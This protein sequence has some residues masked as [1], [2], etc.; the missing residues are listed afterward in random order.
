MKE[1]SEEEF[2]EEKKR[3]GVLPVFFW[4]FL[5]ATV[6]VLLILTATLLSRNG[7]FDRWKAQ[8]T[9]WKEEK[10][11]IKRAETAGEK[12]VHFFGPSGIAEYESW[13]SG[14]W[15]NAIAEGIV[16]GEAGGIEPEEPDPLR[17]ALTESP[18]NGSESWWGSAKKITSDVTVFAQAE[19][20]LYNAPNQ[21]GTVYGYGKA[22]EA[23]RLMAVFKDGWYVVSDG[24]YYYCSEGNRYT[25][26]DLKSVDFETM[27]KEVEKEKV[28]HDVSLILQEPELPHGCEVTG[29][30]MLLSYYGYAEDKC[31]LA[32]Q[33]LP[34]GAWG[35]TNFRKAFV[36][37][38][39]KKVASAGCYA[40]VIADTANRY[41]EEKIGVK[42]SEEGTQGIFEAEIRENLSV[43]PNMEDT[44]KIP[45][46][47]AKEG[48]SFEELLSMVGKGPVLAWMTMELK[49]PYI[50][51]VWDVDGEELY[52]QNCEH[53][54]VLTGYDLDKGVFYGADPL[55]GNCEYDMK[56]FSIRFQTMYS[57]V[58]V[59]E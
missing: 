56:L 18:V 24:R 6:A 38:P 22:G 3:D 34:K 58:V 10:E 25:L 53:C 5:V 59:M 29:L 14:E 55:Y 8:Y 51:Q 17:E 23:F 19:T 57:Q 31:V 1:F 21:S 42:V 50:A 28:Y 32:D 11:A 41:L 40:T 48:V 26:V 27:F 45:K 35:S 2:S 13:F 43:N 15:K 16:E 37:D 52:W 46:A 39:R 49:S 20:P 36:G 4:I 30:A 44:K 12:T 33:W 7:T 9:A 54:V 47:V